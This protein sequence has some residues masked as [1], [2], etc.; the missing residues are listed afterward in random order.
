MPLNVRWRTRADLAKLERNIAELRSELVRLRNDLTTKTGYAATLELV[1]KQRTQTIDN[2][3][4]K[5]EQLRAVNARLDAECEHYFQL[6]AA[7]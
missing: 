7:D 5:V 6:L 3:N 1:I 2:L 4:S